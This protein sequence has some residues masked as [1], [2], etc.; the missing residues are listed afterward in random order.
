MEIGKSLRFYL[1]E[2]DMTV[3]QLARRSGVPAK[4]IYHWLNGQKPSHLGHLFK[5]CE[6]LQISLETLFGKEISEKKTVTTISVSDL[7]TDLNAGHF[8]V[9]L[10]PL[11]REKSL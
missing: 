8:E 5:I 10:R 4:T 2:R 7:T 3:V 11:K 6:V 9:I 1:S